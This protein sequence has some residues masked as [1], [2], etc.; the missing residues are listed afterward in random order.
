MKVRVG[1]ALVAL[2]A[3]GLVSSCTLP[4][5]DLG[6]ATSEA[7][8]VNDAGVIVGFSQLAGSDAQHAFK[9]LPDGTAIDLGTLT[10]DTGSA[11]FEINDDGIAVGWSV[12]TARRVVVWDAADQIHDL[13]FDAIP[14]EIDDAGVI[15][16]YELA[17]SGRPG[18]AA[19]VYDPTVGHAVALPELPGATLSYAWGLNDEGDAVGTVVAGGTG[20]PV[21]WDLDAGTVT[22]LRPFVGADGFVADIGND[23]TLVGTT[24]GGVAAVWAPGATTPTD[25]GV[26]PGVAF[27]LNDSGTVVGYAG[28]HPERAFRWRADTGL[29]WL[30]TA[31]QPAK[32]YDINAAGTVVGIVGVDG[33]TGM[34]DQQAALLSPQ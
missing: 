1:A 27:T 24:G 8:G 12:G 19:F 9:R 30:G 21:R 31:G 5:A 11:A 15:V 4:I 33:V 6:G 10:G 2:A 28:G 17:V 7:Q 26:G 32:A 14:W 18:K 29:E 16:G 13:G 34:T 22:D 20:I 3:I 25:L 23:G